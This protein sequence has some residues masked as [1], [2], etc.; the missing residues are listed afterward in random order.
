MA[1]LCT[2]LPTSILWKIQYNKIISGRAQN[3]EQINVSKKI[4]KL[5]S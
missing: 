1:T 4:L 5:C 2:T 3:M